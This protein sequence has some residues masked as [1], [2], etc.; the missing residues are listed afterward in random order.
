MVSFWTVALPSAVA[1]RSSGVPSLGLIVVVPALMVYTP[2]GF[3]TV[4]SRGLDYHS[5]KRDLARAG[6]D[7]SLQRAIAWW[8]GPSSFLGTCSIGVPLLLTALS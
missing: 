7:R 8:A 1:A 4:P 3:A 5:W 2:F 6:A